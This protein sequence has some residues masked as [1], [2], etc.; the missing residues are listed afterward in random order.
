[1]GLFDF[2]RRN[3][4]LEAQRDLEMKAE[5]QGFVNQLALKLADFWGLPSSEI[6]NKIP[7]ISLSNSKD[8]ALYFGLGDNREIVFSKNN[9]KKPYGTLGWKAVLGEEVGHFINGIIRP[10]MPKDE[11]EFFAIVSRLAVAECEP[12]VFKKEYGDLIR[13]V[14]DYR[15]TKKDFDDRVDKTQKE[16]AEADE[17]YF[18][19]H[20]KKSEKLYDKTWHDFLN[21]SDR[22]NHLLYAPGAYL[23]FRIKDMKP[24]ERLEFSKNPEKA[25]SLIEEGEKGLEEL[26]HKLEDRFG[27][28][29]VESRYKKFVELSKLPENDKQRKEGWK[30]FTFEGEKKEVPF[31]ELKK[32]ALKDTTKGLE[33]VGTFFEKAEKNE[34][35]ENKEAIAAVAAINKQEERKFEERKELE[36]QVQDLIKST[37]NELKKESFSEKPKDS[38]KDISNTELSDA[39]S[40][41]DSVRN[42]K[43]YQEKI[44]EIAVKEQKEKFIPFGSLLKNKT[45]TFPRREKEEK[46]TIEYNLIVPSYYTNR[47]AVVDGIK[48]GIKYTEEKFGIKINIR[49]MDVN[50]ANEIINKT[51]KEIETYPKFYQNDQRTVS[52]KAAYFMP[53]K[54]IVC[55]YFLDKFSSGNTGAEIDPRSFQG[56][57]GIILTSS[58]SANRNLLSHE[59]AHE[60]GLGHCGNPG[61]LTNYTADKDTTA[62]WSAELCP[63]CRELLEKKKAEILEYNKAKF[64]PFGSLIRDKTGTFPRREKEIKEEKALEEQR[65]REMGEFGKEKLDEKAMESSSKMF[66]KAEKEAKLEQQRNL[67]MQIEMQ[68]FVNQL[69]LK[70][71][72]WWGIPQNQIEGNLPR[73]KVLPK[74]EISL[75]KAFYDQK[76][77]EIYFPKEYTRQ[78]YGFM[79]WKAVLGEEVGHFIEG[80]AGEKDSQLREFFGG[81]CRF[82]VA[83]TVEGSFKNDYSSLIR[84]AVGFKE[85]LKYLVPEEAELRE[86]IG[87]GNPTLYKSGPDRLGKEEFDRLVKNYRYVDDQLLHI[88]QKPAAFYFFNVRSMSRDDRHRLITDNDYARSLILK[89]IGK[90]GEIGEAEKFKEKIQEREIAKENPSRLYNEYL[91]EYTPEQL[92]P[93]VDEKGR[94]N[95]VA[96]E[97]QEI[98]EQLREYLDKRI[99][100]VSPFYEKT[101]EEIKK[102]V[103]EKEKPENL[104][105]T[106]VTSTALAIPATTT[107]VIPTTKA[108]VP[109]VQK[110]VQ[111]IKCSTCGKI[112]ASEDEYH[113]AQMHPCVRT[114]IRC[115]YCGSEDVE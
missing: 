100:N 25:K 92:Q 88:L 47:A 60:F 61:C 16:F 79:G 71:A 105:S 85:Q 93:S 114:I 26:K 12:G 112:F 18:K 34:I 46:P 48:R 91:Q 17:K 82:L 28:E 111:P 58:G 22:R 24:A 42:I 29:L 52:A 49:E 63:Q 84:D 83:E 54:S 95:A 11:S 2:F 1:M 37:E 20:S 59:I 41:S 73:I 66:E 97:F 94:I 40:S 81:M 44:R 43:E 31:E 45:G 104:L 90:E 75:K 108:I 4:K 19:E 27:K 10:D 38:I 35:T 57:S 86:K 65:K 103:A 67:E 6:E 15:K 55:L 64:V 113:N 102:A 76:S 62:S 5:A 21:A 87:I 115:P 23:L 36:K 33:N 8:A 69:S 9:F 3:S 101:E 109:I 30:Y 68:G 89:F 96:E 32:E 70:L 110:A 7:K 80:K 50:Q 56:K 99:G 106:A 98:K 53:S 51:K 107:L 39:F 13:E 77:N 72:D 78:P 74:D 14:K